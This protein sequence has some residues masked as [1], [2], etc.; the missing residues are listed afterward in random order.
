MPTLEIDPRAGRVDAGLDEGRG[1]VGRRTSRRASTAQQVTGPGIV[2]TIVPRAAAGRR[3]VRPVAH[4]ERAAAE[5]VRLSDGDR[6]GAARRS[7]RASRC[8]SSA[9][10]RAP[11]ATAPCA[12][13]RIRIWCSAGSTR[14][15]CA[16][17]ID[18]W[19][20]R[21]SRW[22]RPAASPM[23]SSCP[24]AESC[25]LAVTQSRGLGRLLE[26]QLRA[27]PDLI[28]KADGAQHQDQRVPERLR[29]ASHRDDRVPGQRAAC[30]R[31]RRA[32]VLR[33]GRRRR[34]AS[35]APASAGWRRKC[36]RAA[37][38]RSSSG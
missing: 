17:C 21:V 28:A 37:S 22:P 26:D 7:D 31:P 34:R 16:S 32:A 29:P 18:V 23:S 11:T 20:R 35:T 15:T 30:R 12:S 27:R 33:D 14:A 6:H 19:P 10:W 2:P 4:D 9:S 24:G 5:A 36:R 38:R 25:R 8:A 13:R 3:S 1:A